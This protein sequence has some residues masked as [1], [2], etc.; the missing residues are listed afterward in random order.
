M[1]HNKIFDV[2]YIYKLFLRNIDNNIIIKY[3]PKRTSPLLDTYSVLGTTLG[4]SSHLA[5]IGTIWNKHYY[6]LHFAH[7]ETEDWSDLP[8]VTQPEC[9][10]AGI[11]IKVCLALESNLLLIKLV[12]ALQ[13]QN[14]KC[15]C[16]YP[17]YC[18]GLRFCLKRLFIGWTTDLDEI[19]VPTS[20]FH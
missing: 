8:K 11:L 4:A 2:K 5:L 14:R 10:Q 6:C 7:E 18:K 12:I 3:Q 20:I 17:E 13:G 15:M 16:G 19:H 9:D 1:S